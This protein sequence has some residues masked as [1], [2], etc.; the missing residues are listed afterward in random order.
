MKLKIDQANKTGVLSGLSAVVLVGVNYMSGI[1]WQWGDIDPD[2]AL[3]W[4]GSIFAL[5]FYTNKEN[6]KKPA[7]GEVVTIDSENGSLPLGL[8][9]NNPGNIRPS[10]RYKW[11]G[12]VG[13]YESKKGPFVR[14]DNYESGIR[15]LARD[16]MTKQRKH[17]LRTIRGIISRYAPPSEND[18]EAYISSV[19]RQTKF[20]ADEKLDVEKPATAVRMIKAIIRHEQGR[21]PF[22]TETIL[23]GVNAA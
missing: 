14:F 16:L 23:Q 3:A 18:T 13:V 17:G 2:R 5:V 19:V 9:I 11:K 22:S 12:E 20:G 10:S 8:R 4:M 7:D 21:Q 6:R 15:A 1:E